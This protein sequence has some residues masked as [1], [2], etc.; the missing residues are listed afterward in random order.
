MRNVDQICRDAYD[1]IIIGGGIYGSMLLLEASRAG[2]KAILLEKDDFGGLTSFNSLRIVHGGL[3]Y[4]QTLHLS[5]LHESVT[6]RSWFLRSFPD[7][8]SPLPCLM[9]FYRGLT[10]NRLTLSAAL[11]MNDWLTRNRNEGLSEKFQI[12][13]GQIIGA[14]ETRQ[15]FPLAR[16]N[17][18]RGA[19]L[20]YDAA[21]PDSKSID[22][23]Y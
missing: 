5:R 13:D 3:R 22:R 17:G 8:V 14:A 2:L 11:R 18:L 12:P 9:P 10:K 20:W 7:L 4:L 6:E 16:A 23:H 19:A 15:R 1:V 21:M